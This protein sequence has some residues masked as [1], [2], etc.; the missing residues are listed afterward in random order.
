MVRIL[1]SCWK[2]NLNAFS[3]ARKLLV[4]CGLKF[5]VT[6]L[7][8][9]VIT[10]E[11]HPIKASIFPRRLPIIR[12]FAF[13]FFHLFHQFVAHL[14]FRSRFFKTLKIWVFFKTYMG[15]FMKSLNFN[16]IAKS[17]NFFPE[18]ATNGFY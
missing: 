7:L 11:T 18:G 2:Y 5:P 4:H 16:K 13:T 12:V 15:F 8:F 14:P 9:Y 10:K 1:Q 3:I 6:L 17:S